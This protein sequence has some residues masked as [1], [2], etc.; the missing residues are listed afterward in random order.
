MKR[1]IVIAWFACALSACGD[2]SSEDGAPHAG[3]PADDAAISDAPSDD[4]GL[5]KH[6]TCDPAGSGVCLND[7]DCPVVVSGAARQS[8]TDCGISCL[9]DDDQDGCAQTCVI[10]DTELNSACAACYVATVACT[11][12]HCLAPCLSDADSRACYDCQV[13]NDCRSAFEACSGLPPVA[14]P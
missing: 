13:A 11:R 5:P 12:D 7:H 9:G 2:D 4:A 10:D 14:R 3:A 6:I 1:F 8:A